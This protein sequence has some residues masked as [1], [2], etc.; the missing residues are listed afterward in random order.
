MSSIWFHKYTLNAIFIEANAKSAFIAWLLDFFA[1][2]NNLIFCH[3]LDQI[4]FETEGI[5]FLLNFLIFR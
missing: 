1:I 5:V 2:L 4:E 3:L